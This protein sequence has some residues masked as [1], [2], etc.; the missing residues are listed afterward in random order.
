MSIP[1]NY[2]QPE[3]CPSRSHFVFVSICPPPT[4]QPRKALYEFPAVV[5]SASGKFMTVAVSFTRSQICILL[6]RELVQLRGMAF[7]Q[8]SS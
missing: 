8:S 3:K 4:Q 6:L 1:R 2:T 5:Q 7:E